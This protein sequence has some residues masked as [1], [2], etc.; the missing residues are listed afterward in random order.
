[1]F[2]LWIQKEYHFKIQ[3]FFEKNNFERIIFYL[4]LSIKQ[5]ISK[6]SQK[7]TAIF[8]LWY[9]DTWNVCSFSSHKVV[10]CQKLKE[11]LWESFKIKIKKLAVFSFY[12]IKVQ[13]SEL[14]NLKNKNCK[15]S[16]FQKYQSLISI[17]SFCE[18]VNPSFFN[19]L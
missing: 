11:N 3:H 10:N 1:M 8:S 2:C 9:K 19:I 12:L 18:A 14:K 13:F 7:E 4:K 15:H 5:I 6:I 16:C 17:H